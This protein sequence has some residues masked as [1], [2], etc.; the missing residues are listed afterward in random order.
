MIID[1]KKYNGSCSCKKTHMM[2]TEACVIESGCLLKANEYIKNYGLNGYSVAIYDENTY[3]VTKDCHPKVDKEI[4]LSPCAI[5]MTADKI[6]GSFDKI[7]EIVNTIPTHEELI[8][9]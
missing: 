2:T 9:I 4:I 7:K 3:E 5:S 8:E 6:K 1:S